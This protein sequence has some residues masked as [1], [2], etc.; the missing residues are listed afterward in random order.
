MTAITESFDDGAL[1]FCTIIGE[2]TH[3]WYSIV[4]VMGADNIEHHIINVALSNQDEAEHA[5]HE[6]IEHFKAIL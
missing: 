1:H 2:E 3:G 5:K 6:S 4:V